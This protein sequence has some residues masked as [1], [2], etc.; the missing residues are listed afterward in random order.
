MIEPKSRAGGKRPGSGRKPVPYKVKRIKVCQK[1]HS[2]LKR[3]TIDLQV[4]NPP[5]SPVPRTI[6]ALH[7]MLLNLRS[8]ELLSTLDVSPLREPYGWVQVREFD[9]AALQ[10]I[11]RICKTTI[12]GAV[13]KLVLFYSINAYENFSLASK[14]QG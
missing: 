12:S 5:N 13:S 9:F 1:T 7:L 10:A 6:D 14:K 11:S 4:T 3:Y 2:A 8:P